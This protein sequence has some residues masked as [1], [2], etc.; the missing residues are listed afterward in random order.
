MWYDFVYIGGIV[1]LTVSSTQM[2]QEPAFVTMAIAATRMHRSLVNFT[3][4][5]KDLCNSPPP[6]PDAKY[7]NAARRPSNLMEVAVHMVSEQHWISQTT[8]DES[9]ISTDAQTRE[10]QSSLCRD[11]DLERGVSK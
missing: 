6:I 8:E 4:R 9:G 1:S 11:D 7:S 2:F 10:K 3:S 5:P